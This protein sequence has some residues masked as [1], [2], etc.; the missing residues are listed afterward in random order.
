LGNEAV[1]KLSSAFAKPVC[2]QRQ[3]QADSLIVILSLSKYDN[4]T[5]FWTASFCLLN[6]EIIRYAWLL[7]YVLCLAVTTQGQ[8]V[9]DLVFIWVPTAQ[10]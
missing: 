8:A 5:N 7:F 6:A 3:A 4:Q 1:Q 2:R 9:D 10:G